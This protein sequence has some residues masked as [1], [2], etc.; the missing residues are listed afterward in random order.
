[1]KQIASP[2]QVAMMVP[3]G[4]SDLKS[5]KPERKGKKTEHGGEYETSG[6]EIEPVDQEQEI[7]EE[8]EIESGEE[9]EE[10]F[11]IESGEKSEE[12]FEIGSE[13]EVEVEFEKEFREKIEEKIEKKSG[14][15]SE[16]GIEMGGVKKE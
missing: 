6:I 4:E 11:E 16:E 1:M 12:E 15:G 14:G 7:E 13:E 2:D 10:E 3:P 9:S 5:Q 8:F